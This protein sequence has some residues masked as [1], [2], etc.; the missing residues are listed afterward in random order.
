MPEV[1]FFFFVLGALKKKK[2]TVTVRRHLML[3]FPLSTSPNIEIF[4]QKSNSS[5]YYFLG[6]NN[7]CILGP[8]LLLRL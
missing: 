2:A 7:K 5:I 1:F 6:P 8:R 4:P 3:I